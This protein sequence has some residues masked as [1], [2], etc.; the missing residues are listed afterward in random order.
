MVV[1]KKEQKVAE[2]EVP[3]EH[4]KGAEF[5]MEFGQAE[6]EELSVLAGLSEQLAV[7]GSVALVVPLSEK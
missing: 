2:L 3:F 6:V 4:L 5:G 1:G 7:A